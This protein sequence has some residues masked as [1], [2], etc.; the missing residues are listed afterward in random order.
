M[1][2]NDF[3]LI[4]D[5]LKERSG[6]TLARERAYLLESRLSS[7]ARKWKFQGFDE[8]AGAVR[9][10]GDE[11][12]LSDIVQAMTITETHFFRD[13]TPFYQ[14]RDLVL[15][16]LL[17][18]K[19]EARS[20]RVW[21]AGCSSGQEVYS[22]AMMLEDRKEDLAGWTYEI[23][24][25]DLSIEMLARAKQGLYTQLEV[26]RGLPITYLIKYFEQENDRWR[27]HE[28]IRQMTRFQPLNLLDDMGSMGRFDVVFCRYVLGGFDPDVRKRTLA[29]ITGQLTDDGVLYLGLDESAECLSGRLQPIPG[30]RGLYG[31]DDSMADDTRMAS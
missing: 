20:F 27:I 24:G 15:P 26:Q 29:G 22:I 12:L 16:H 6:F 1:N 8:L 5:I 11:A 25:T 13:R 9:E 30:A 4:A 19:A 31:L 7:V 17:Q 28:P 3:E 23:V 10:N 21:C 14:F 18:Q 2:V